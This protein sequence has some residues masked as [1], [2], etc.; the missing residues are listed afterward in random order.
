[1]SKITRFTRCLVARP[2]ILTLVQA[3]PNVLCKDELMH[4]WPLRGY[5]TL[6]ELDLDMGI[7][8]D[9]H[10]NGMFDMLITPYTVDLKASSVRKG[11]C[12]L[13][14]QP[15]DID[16]QRSG[17]QGCIYPWLFRVLQFLP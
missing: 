15:V 13:C 7:H 17:D 9:Q 8:T 12:T 10:G 4:G 14:K 5:M 1:M 2:D 3:R 6:Y 16:D 11:N